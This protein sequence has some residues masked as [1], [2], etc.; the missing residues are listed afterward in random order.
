MYPLNTRILQT[1]CLRQKINIEIMLINFTFHIII[2]KTTGLPLQP[3]SISISRLWLPLSRD[4]L[5]TLAIG[6]ELSYISISDL[7][8]RYD[9]MYVYWFSLA[10][11]YLF[12]LYCFNGP[13]D[14]VLA[15]LGTLVQGDGEA[16]RVAIYFGDVLRSGD[17]TYVGADLI[18][19]QDFNWIDLE[20]VVA[21]FLMSGKL[22]GL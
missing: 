18:G 7:T 16:L 20:L 13:A 15:V 4:M 19:W 12:V 6:T 21:S 8:V 9:R 2:H 17:C 3:T 11:C 10:S 14:V 22:L 5:H 1:I